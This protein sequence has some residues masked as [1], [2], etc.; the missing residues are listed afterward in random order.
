MTLLADRLVQ[1]GSTQSRH[2]F[3]ETLEELL[4]R[5]K[6]YE[7]EQLNTDK[8]N[9]SKQEKEKLAAEELRHKAMHGNVCRNWG[10][11]VHGGLLLLVTGQCWSVLVSVKSNCVNC[12]LER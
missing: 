1:A 4:E 10:G 2:R 3:D 9:S 5:V 8:E 11:T 7:D 12:R 6:A